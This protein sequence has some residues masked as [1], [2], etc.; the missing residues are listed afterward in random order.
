M[1]VTGDSVSM[2]LIEDED[3][4]PRIV[5]VPLKNI[6][7]MEELVSRQCARL[8]WLMIYFS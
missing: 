4:H 3:E 6:A 8:R 7:S 5:H 1:Y 2:E